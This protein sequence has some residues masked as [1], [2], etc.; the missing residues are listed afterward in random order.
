LHLTISPTDVRG[1]NRGHFLSLR[2]QCGPFDA[3]ADGYE[4]GEARAVVFCGEAP[5][6]RVLGPQPHFVS[7]AVRGPSHARAFDPVPLLILASTLHF[8]LEQE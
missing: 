8:W 5:L 1:L 7:S 3:S 2:V 4:R 6:H